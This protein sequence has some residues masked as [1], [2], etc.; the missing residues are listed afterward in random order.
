MD[1]EFISFEEPRLPVLVK[2]MR[3]GE[4]ITYRG[5]HIHKEIELLYPIEGSLCGI[6]DGESF[7]LRAG[8]VLLINRGVPHL[9][10]RSSSR[11][12]F[13]YV[14]VDIE[15]LSGAITHDKALLPLWGG[16][17]LKKCD[18]DTEGGELFE[19]F[20]ALVRE[21]TERQE[22]FEVYLEATALR[23][24]AYMMRGGMLPYGRIRA[25][26]REKR[27]YEMVRYLEANYKRDIT[28]DELASHFCISKGYFC[29]I[30]KGMTGMSFT[31]YLNLIRLHHV[32][33]ELAAT[34]KSIAEVAFEQGFSSL[35]YFYTV[36]KQYKKC[37]PKTFRRFLAANS[38]EDS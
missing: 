28:L 14:Q 34:D 8:E 2:T 30:F 9:I 3:G 4:N 38:R 20:S 31:Q 25:V 21:S 35:Q 36:F 16:P 37:T 29:R 24:A 1:S 15:K 19:I 12:G 6:I 17:P 27:G 23:L 26:R 7:T 5:E 18:K 22:A 11:K 32:E 13:T 10:Q 33:A